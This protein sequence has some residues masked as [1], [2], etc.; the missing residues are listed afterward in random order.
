MAKA[1]R[2]TRQRRLIL[3][4]LRSTDIHPTADWIYHQARKHIPDISL[5][6]VYRNLNQLKQAGEIMELNYGSTFSRYDGNPCN[7]YH[8]VCDACGRVFDVEMP[9]LSGIE[10]EAARLS[11]MKVTRHRLEFYG[12]C[13]ECQKSREEPKTQ[14]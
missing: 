3:E 14:G 10:E 4:I 2:M 9:V 5:G 12:Y 1:T 13:R 8:F 7:H 6:T 11:G